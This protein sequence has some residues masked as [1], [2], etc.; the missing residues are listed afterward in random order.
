MSK[1]NGPCAQQGNL[2]DYSMSFSGSM[3]KLRSMDRCAVLSKHLWIRPAAA[4]DSWDCWMER[5][6]TV[7]SRWDLRHCAK[8]DFALYIRGRLKLDVRRGSLLLSGRRIR[9]NCRNSKA[10]IAKL[11]HGFHS[12]RTSDIVLLNLSFMKTTLI[13]SVIK[14]FSR[15]SSYPILS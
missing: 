6:T 12:S 2:Q 9:H 10:Q 14:N 7:R 5:G 13:L 4:F 8:R 15:T 11:S 3:K 1:Y